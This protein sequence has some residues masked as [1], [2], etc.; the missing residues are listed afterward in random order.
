VV[1]GRIIVL[2]TKMLGTHSFINGGGLNY[3]RSEGEEPPLT[4]GRLRSF[5]YPPFPATWPLLS[6]YIAA[7][8]LSKSGYLSNL[9]KIS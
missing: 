5:S 4:C 6:W 9:P 1:E 3:S 7:V 8:G 2:V